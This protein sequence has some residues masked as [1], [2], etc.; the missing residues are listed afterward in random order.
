MGVYLCLG[1]EV[2]EIKQQNILAE[3]VKK[4]NLETLNERFEAGE[5]IFIVLGRSQHKIK[6]KAE[7]VACMEALD[8]MV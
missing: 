3:E 6:K 5:K 7:Q 2:H 8:K 4:I 1:Y